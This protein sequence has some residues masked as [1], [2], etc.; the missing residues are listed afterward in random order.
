MQRAGCLPRIPR[1]RV[2]DQNQREVRPRPI[3][4]EFNWFSDRDNVWRARSSLKGTPVHLEE[5]H[6][7]EIEDR[8]YRLM[9]VY[10]KAMS[11]PEYRGRT[12]LN[13]DILTIK[14]EQ[15]TADKMDHL[16]HDLDQG[17]L[18]PAAKG[19][20]RY[21]FLVTVPLATTSQLR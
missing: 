21:S 8:R 14:G 6:P 20:L 7:E 16:P 5:D 9:P 2:P 12:F 11:M 18:P 19:T 17:T 3:I 15:F 4:V 1:G 10:N 13:G